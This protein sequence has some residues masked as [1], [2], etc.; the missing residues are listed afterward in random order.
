MEGRANDV[1]QFLARYAIYFVVP[2]FWFAYVG[3]VSP[4][5]GGA[6]GFGAALLLAVPLLM[7]RRR[8]DRA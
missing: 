7:R 5:I 3:G 1:V 2:G 6:A 8:A 4:W